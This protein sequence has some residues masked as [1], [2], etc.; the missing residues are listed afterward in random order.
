MRLEDGN[1]TLALGKRS[2]D[3]RFSINRNGVG[4]LIDARH[5]KSCRTRE[6]ES[7]SPSR[8]RQQTEEDGSSFGE[9]CALSSLTIRERGK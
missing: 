6:K 3:K 8:P 7:N 1:L 9:R 4:N 5:Q 2:R